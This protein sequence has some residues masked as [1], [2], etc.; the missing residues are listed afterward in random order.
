MTHS[1]RFARSGRGI[2]NER[3]QGTTEYI[4]LIILV[5]LVCIPVM[6]LLPKAVRGYVRPF[7]YCVSRPL[8]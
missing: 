4:V 7:Y 8:P 6:T 2:R 5:S 1:T 3:G